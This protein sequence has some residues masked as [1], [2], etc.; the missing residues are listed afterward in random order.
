MVRQ[1][2][3]AQRGQSSKRAEVGQELLE[4]LTVLV[5][6]GGRCGLPRFGRVHD[7]TFAPEG[8]RYNL[9]NASVTVAFVKNSAAS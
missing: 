5:V 9:A 7:E 6:D 2:A 4:Q 1:A 8:T 3:V